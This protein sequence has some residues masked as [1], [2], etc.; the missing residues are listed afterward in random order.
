MGP[1]S[2]HSCRRRRPGSERRGAAS[3]RQ[4]AAGRRMPAARL[5]D[6]WADTP[7]FVGYAV[8]TY[9]QPAGARSW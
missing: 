5:R 9:G 2:T 8:Q 6:S 7:A 4:R 3:C 1:S